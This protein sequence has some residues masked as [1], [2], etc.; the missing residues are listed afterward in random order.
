MVLIDISIAQSKQD[1][2]NFHIPVEWIATNQFALRSQGFSRS[3]TFQPPILVLECTVL[4][5]RDLEAKDADG[6]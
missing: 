2:V 5:A 4:E 1:I 6:K 3:D